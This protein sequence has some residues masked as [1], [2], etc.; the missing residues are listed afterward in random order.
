M[1]NMRAWDGRE[2]REVMVVIVVVEK[3]RSEGETR[4]EKQNEMRREIYVS[5]NVRYEYV[6][7]WYAPGRY[8][9]SR[10]VS[11]EMREMDGCV[12]MPEVVIVKG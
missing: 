6:Y 4:K 10:F 8:I 2:M 9:Q 1:V 11:F 12:K 3:E 7:A 5:K